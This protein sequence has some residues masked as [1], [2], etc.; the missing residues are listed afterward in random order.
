MHQQQGLTHLDRA[1]LERELA[2]IFSRWEPGWLQRVEFSA[3]AWV[4]AGS[5]ELT[6][7]Q[8]DKRLA[9]ERLR[10]ERDTIHRGLADIL[11][12]TSV[13]NLKLV[14]QRSFLDWLAAQLEQS[15][16]AA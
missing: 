6:I 15:R 13:V 10:A 7:T 5:A 2:T 12:S 1:D 4:V 16:V 8:Q 14:A 3:W 11:L 9:I